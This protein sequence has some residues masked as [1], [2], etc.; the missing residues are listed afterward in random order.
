MRR[1]K[2]NE[3]VHEVHDAKRLL[4]GGQKNYMGIMVHSTATPGVMAA[5][6]FRWN[7]SIRLVKQIGVC[8]HAFVDD[9]EVWQYLPWNHRGWHCAAPATTRT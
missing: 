9:K 5:T 8:V 3:A 6:G 7:K 2:R 1:M 4:Y